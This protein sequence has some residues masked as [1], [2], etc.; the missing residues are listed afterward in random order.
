MKNNEYISNAIRFRNESKE[1]RERKE[2]ERACSLPALPNTEI[3]YP[4]PRRKGST[5]RPGPG[6]WKTFLGGCFA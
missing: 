3:R 5:G 1:W 6:G 2:R 4:A